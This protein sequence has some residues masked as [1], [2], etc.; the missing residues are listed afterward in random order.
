[1]KCAGCNEAVDFLY[2]QLCLKCLWRNVTPPGIQ[3]RVCANCRVPKPV[4]MFKGND[5]TCSLCRKLMIV[6]KVRYSHKMQISQATMLGARND[7][8]VECMSCGLEFHIA[9][10]PRNSFE[11]AHCWGIRS[12]T[13]LVRVNGV[14]D[15]EVRCFRCY[16]LTYLSQLPVGRLICRKCINK[17]NGK[18]L[19]ER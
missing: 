12:L 13:E 14:Y 5:S 11:C 3:F 18:K 15:A 6:V 7:N 1:M 17:E 16:D 9:Q 10:F 2:K 19:G 4:D 8:Y